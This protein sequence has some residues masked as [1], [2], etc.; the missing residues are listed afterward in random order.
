MPSFVIESFCIS[1][2]FFFLLLSVLCS[3][4]HLS[5]FRPCFF[6]LIYY[7]KYFDTIN[8]NSVVFLLSLLLLLLFFFLLRMFVNY[9][10][11]M[12]L[13]N[14]LHDV[15]TSHSVVIV[16]K[17]FTYF[18]FGI[19]YNLILGTRQL[20]KPKNGLDFWPKKKTENKIE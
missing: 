16:S 9:L 15:D 8:K 20:S 11:S 5:D 6:S 13:R 18:D 4:S 7:P 10:I 12:F 14:C 17:Y 3:V 2:C 1:S 19:D